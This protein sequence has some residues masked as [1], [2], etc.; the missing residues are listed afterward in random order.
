MK[1]SLSWLKDHLETTA[2]AAT[3]ADK[4]TSIGLEVE[5]VEDSGARLKDFIV[6]YVISAEKHPNADKL[7]LCMVDVGTGTPIQVVCGAPNAHTGM[8][9]VFARTGVVIPV[10]GDMLKVG[11]IRGVESHGM[12][13]S[14]RELLLS[15]DRDGIIELPPDAKVGEPAAKAL[16]LNDPVI[17]VAITP[18]RGDC[19]SVYGIARDLAA[20]GLGKLKTA[21][22]KPVS[23]TFPSPKNIF[24]N[25]TALSARR[26]KWPITQLGSG[27]FEI[28]RSQAN[29]GARR[30]VEPGSA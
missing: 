7:K 19:T 1:F 8:K 10:N 17:D 15:D 24:L 6:A 21:P 12:L 26:K 11:T 3:I 14:G 23:G 18:N 4:L 13:C 20:A 9:G 27:S 25:F 28:H 2:D 5:S 16:G 30:C 29:F 22:V